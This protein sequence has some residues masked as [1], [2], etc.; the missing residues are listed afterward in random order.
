MLF[1]I[2]ALNIILIGCIAWWISRRVASDQRLIFWSGLGV[3][4]TAGICLGLVYSYH[5]RLGDTLGFFADAVLLN[6]LAGENFDQYLG[7][8]I[9]GTPPIELSNHEPRAFFF[10]ALVSIVNFL[11]GKNYWLS[12]LWFSLF[13][14]LC[15]WYFLQQLTVLLPALRRAG[16]I[17]FLFFPSVVFWSSGIVKES[18]GFGALCLVAGIFCRIMQGKKLS[19]YEYVP[20]IVALW[21]LLNLKYYWAAVF[22]PSVLTTLVVYWLVERRVSGTWPLVTCWLAIFIFFCWAASFTH[23]NF[24]LET[25]LG[26]IRQNHDE[27]VRVSNPDNVIHFAVQVNSWSDVVVNAPWAIISGLFRP[28]PHEA[29]GITGVVGSLENLAILG[30]VLLKFFRLRSVKGSQ[31]LLLLSVLAYSLLLCI[32]LAMSTPNFGTLSRYR[33]GFLPF[34]MMIV[35]HNNPLLTL[36]L[37]GRTQ[38]L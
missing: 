24:Y 10:T 22:V 25:F 11:S 23:P 30:L 5:Y 15:V 34:F 33:I 16:V 14:F 7:A 9:S 6:N 27:F 1:G 4:L 13:S 12:S 18:V 8:L 17:A 36:K 20:L 26:V 21:L 19:W 31:R 37:W 29:H 35:L 28:L 38:R 3:K 2:G 32:F